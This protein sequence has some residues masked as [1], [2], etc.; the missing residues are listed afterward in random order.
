MRAFEKHLIKTNGEKYSF[1]YNKT[2]T[3]NGEGSDAPQRAYD[4]AIH[5][6]KT[7]LFIDSDNIDKWKVQESKLV[8]K[9]VHV[10][11]WQNSNNTEMQL[12]SDV[13][14][15]HIFDLINIAIENN[16]DEH[17]FLDSINSSL[18]IKLESLDLIEEYNDEP[19]LRNA[20]AHSANKNDWYK[21]VSK[22]ENLGDY[23]FNLGSIIKTEFYKRFESIQTWVKNAQ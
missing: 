9:G 1:P 7:C 18:S 17:S 15:E 14:R 19:C 23:L 6:Y 5:N 21:T 16:A 2:I 11:R 22:A 10:V 4:L 12:F 13:P 3:V 8:S 20:V